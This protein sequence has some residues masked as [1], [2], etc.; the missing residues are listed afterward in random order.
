MNTIAL[1]HHG[2]ALILILAEYMDRYEHFKGDQNY[3]D[4]HHH[5]ADYHDHHHYWAD[6]H[7]HHHY[8]AHY[9]YDH[10]RRV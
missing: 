1:D 8:W 4:D 9:Y 2:S 10:Q 7:D 5:W 6:Y 3:D